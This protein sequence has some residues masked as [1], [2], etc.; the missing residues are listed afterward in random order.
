[1]GQVGGSLD[2]REGFPPPAEEAQGRTLVGERLGDDTVELEVL[3]EVE[4]EVGGRYRLFGHV[5]SHERPREIRQ[6]R[7]PDLPAAH[8]RERGDSS[9]ENLDGLLRLTRV[10]EDL[11]EEG[12]AGADATLIARGAGKVDPLPDERPRRHR[13]WLQH[14]PTL[15]LG[16]A[17]RRARPDRRRSRWPGAGRRWPARG[18]PAWR[19][20]RRPPTGPGVPGSRS[21][22]PPRP[23]PMPRARRRSAT[24]SA[25][26]SSSSPSASK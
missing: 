12:L 20:A 16:A 19:P 5:G 8:L 3:R 22:R 9:F 26:A 4:G 14:S 17:A 1:M 21:R 13:G 6:E 2:E 15:P 11:A 24:A 10:D 23:P 7:G 25:P 18:R